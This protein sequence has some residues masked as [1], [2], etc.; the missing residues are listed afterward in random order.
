MAAFAVMGA[1]RGMH[2]AFAA[3]DHCSFVVDLLPYAAFSFSCISMN[4][5]LFT[6]LLQNRIETQ[7]GE[8]AILRQK[9]QSKSE[10]LIILTKELDRA[11]EGEGARHLLHQAPTL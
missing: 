6:L 3:I 9:L 10:A 11:R 8:N 5:F 1:I 2:G 4:R 7:R